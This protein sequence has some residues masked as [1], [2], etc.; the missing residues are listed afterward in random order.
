MRAVGIAAGLR[1]LLHRQKGGLKQ[2]LRV[3]DAHPDQIVLKGNP[4][5]LRVQMLEMGGAQTQL[6]RMAGNGVLLVQRIL[7]LQAQTLELLKV[8]ADG[9]PV[10]PGKA[11]GRQMVEKHIEQRVNIPGGVQM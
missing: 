10:L 11:G 4:K 5:K 7:N 9:L 2:F 1:D 6:L 8:R 3:V